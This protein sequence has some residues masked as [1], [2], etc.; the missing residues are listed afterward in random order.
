MRFKWFSYYGIFGDLD[1]TQWVDG[2]WWWDLWIGSQSS[3][4]GVFSTSK[5]FG[6]DPMK[7]LINQD[8]PIHWVLFLSSYIF[9]NIFPLKLFIFIWD[10]IN[11]FFILKVG[12]ASSQQVKCS[13]SELRTQ[14][15]VYS[16]DKLQNDFKVDIMSSA[17]IYCSDMNE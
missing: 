14:K 15:N 4:S 11:Y 2:S 7:N 9:M 10:T 6:W 12:V 8:S 5:I 1:K 17:W 16:T 13:I 3:L